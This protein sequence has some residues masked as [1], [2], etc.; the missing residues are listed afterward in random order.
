MR[1]KSSSSLGLP[2]MMLLMQGESFV[3]LG[4]GEVS[5][6]VL[7]VVMIFHVIFYQDILWSLCSVGDFFSFSVVCKPWTQS[8][9]IVKTVVN[10]LR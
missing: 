6:F 7:V 10:M 1:G 4:G 5:R 2:F 9:L 8:V 3:G